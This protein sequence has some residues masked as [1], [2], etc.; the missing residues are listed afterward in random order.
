MSGPAGKAVKLLKVLLVAGLVAWGAFAWW[1]IRRAR[2]AGSAMVETIGATWP[3]SGGPRID[4]RGR[5]LT[6]AEE[7]RAGDFR[8]VLDDLG[9]LQEPT[10]EERAAAQRFFGKAPEVRKR[11]LAAAAAARQQE[12]EDVD[13]SAVRDALGRALAAAIRNDQQKAVKQIEMAETALDQADL[14][15]AGGLSEGG[16]EAVAELVR[17]IGPAFDLGRELMTEGHTAAEKLLDRAGRHY[18]AKEYR[19]AASLVRLAA[20]LLGVEL[21]PPAVAVVPKWF[22]ELGRQ[23]L[24]D[25]PQPQAAA[26]VE[27]CRAM[28]ASQPP[29]SPV[30]TL[31]D[32]AARELDA[33]RPAEAYWWATA[34]LSSLGMTDEAIA[35]ATEGSQ[36]EAPPKKT[37]AVETGR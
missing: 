8:S 16:R 7:F 4:A 30:K 23:P 2:Q 36:A 37:P 24:A 31:I 35:A 27:L 33:G 17:R 10:A 20:E 19:Q 9:P 13:V 34:A 3:E 32:K 1:T 26:A 18:R 11:F 28:A 14:G 29:S 6:A 22:D 12:V 15:L 25:A 5:L 21:P